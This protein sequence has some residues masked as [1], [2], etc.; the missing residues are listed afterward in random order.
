MEHC[1]SGTLIALNQAKRPG[2]YLARSAPSDVARVTL[3][4]TAW[5]GSGR[6]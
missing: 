5:V 2:C 1:T 3:S 6:W 4:R